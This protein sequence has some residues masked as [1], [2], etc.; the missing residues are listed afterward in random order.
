M[1]SKNLTVEDN[2]IKTIKIEFLNK[3]YLLS[4]HCKIRFKFSPIQ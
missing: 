1:Q 3:F 2:R 4:E